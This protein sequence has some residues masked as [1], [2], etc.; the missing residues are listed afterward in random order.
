LAI[1]VLVVVVVS[2]AISVDISFVMAPPSPG[3]NGISDDRSVVAVTA[4]FSSEVA[5]FLVKNP[6]SGGS[7][8]KFVEVV[9]RIDAVGVV[10]NE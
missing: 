9:R 3:I 10:V 7:P 1:S 8:C 2:R 4:V 6:G 5:L